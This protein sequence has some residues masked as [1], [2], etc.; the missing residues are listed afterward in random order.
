MAVALHVADD[1]LDGASAPPLAADG[2][3]EAALL[4]GEDD[5]S[6][7]GIVAAVAAV[8]IGALDPDAGEAL[9]PGDLR[10]QGAAVVG[11]ARQGAGAE[12]ELPAGGRC[13]WWRPRPSRRT[14]TGPA[15]CPFRC[16]PPPARAGS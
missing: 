6:P 2:R 7:I 9:G 14:R 10:G 12:D 4:A 5:A 11:V 16:T 8:D 3:R 1:G 13:W 15:P